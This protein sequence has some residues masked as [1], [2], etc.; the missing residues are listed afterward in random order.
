MNFST[1]NQK[2]LEVY[3]SKKSVFKLDK[4]DISSLIELAKKNPRK[5]VRFCSHSSSND[6]IHEMF[7]IHPRGAY[8]RPHKHLNKIESMLIIDGEVDYV[9]FD[10]EGKIKNIVCM[11]SFESKKPFY[12]TIR[13]DTFHTLLIKSEWL[14]FLEITQGPFNEKD[15][16]Y[17]EWSP[18]DNQSGKINK[19]LSELSQGVT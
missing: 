9:I 16:I 11:G 3:H 7:I 2:N 17:A 10:E 13:K 12:H 5:R 15:T 8:I 1:Q 6:S 19:Y 4:K 14:V 18:N